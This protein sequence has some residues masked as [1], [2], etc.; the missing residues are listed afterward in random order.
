[1]IRKTPSILE[2][3]RSF[4]YQNGATDFQTAVEYFAVFGGMGWSVDMTRPLNELIEEKILHNCRYIHGDLTKIT[5]SKP[6]YHAMLTAIAIGDRREHSSFK[7]INIGR[8][9]GEEIIDFLIKDG[10]VVFDVSV[11]KPINE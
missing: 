7:K 11:E 2:Q 9:E 1:M 6:K 4:C 10:F 5:H 3:F 8:E